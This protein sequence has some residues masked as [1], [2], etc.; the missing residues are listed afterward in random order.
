MRKAISGG[1]RKGRSR[2]K[3]ALKARRRLKTIKPLLDQ[4]LDITDEEESDWQPEEEKQQRNPFLGKEV[5]FIEPEEEEKFEEEVEEMPRLIIKT[6]KLKKPPKATFL[7]LF[8]FLVRRPFLS[9]FLTNAPCR[10]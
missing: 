2:R 3:A 10:V 4:L 8:N 7:F 5:I 1:K 6:V 9:V